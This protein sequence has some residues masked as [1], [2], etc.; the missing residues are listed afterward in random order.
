MTNSLRKYI[1]VVFLTLAGTLQGISQCVDDFPVATSLGDTVVNIC[2]GSADPIVRVAPGIRGFAIMYILTDANNTILD[3]TTNPVFNFR[4]APPGVCRI[5]AATFK[6]RILNTVGELLDD[7]E[8]TTLCWGLSANWVTIIRG[9]A[10]ESTVSITGGATD[11]TFC[12]QDGLDDILTFENTPTTQAYTYV[13]T[14]EN[15]MILDVTT[16]QVN[17]EGAPAGVCYVYGLSYDGALLAMPGMDVD[18]QLSEGCSRLSDNRVEVTRVTTDA[19]MILTT[20]SLTQLV[21]CIGDSMSDSIS[22]INPGA[23]PNANYTYIVTDD[24][25]TI[26]A[27]LPGNTVDFEG[28]GVGVCR[29][30]GVA[31]TGNLTATPGTLL[32]TITSDGACLGITSTFVRAVRTSPMEGRISTLGGDTLVFTCQGDSIDD[33][34][35]VN[36]LSGTSPFIFIITDENG[37]VLATSPNQ[38]INFEGAGPGTC[39]IWRAAYAGNLV[40]DAGDEL[41]VDPVSDGCFAISDNA[42]EVRRLN[43]DAGEIADMNGNT[44]SDI[45]VGDG[46]PDVYTFEGSFNPDAPARLVITDGDDNVL[47]IIPIDGEVDFDGAGSGACRVYG[48]SYAGDLLLEAG[49]NLLTDD[50]ATVCSDISDNFV[51]FNRSNVDPGIIFTQY[52]DIAFTC[53]GD[54]NPDLIFITRQSDA[55]SSIVIVTDNSGVVLALPQTDTVDFEGA[56]EGTCLI[57]NFAFD[58]NLLIAV[59]DTIMGQDLASGCFSLS[60]PVP[61]IRRV[62]ISDSL[63][64]MGGATELEFCTSDGIDDLVILNYGPTADFP[65]E[66]VITDTAGL[67]LGTSRNDTINFEGVPAGICYVYGVAYTG[68]FTGMVGQNIGSSD[69]SD[70]CYAI[71]DNFVQVTR[72]EPIGGQLALDNGEVIIY[73]CPSDGNPDVVRYER[74]NGAGDNFQYIITDEFDVALGFTT[75]DTF[76]FEGAGFGSCRIWG[77]AYAGNFMGEAGDT[78]T[79][80]DLADDCFALTDNFITVV[81]DTA[82]GGMVTTIQ[83]DTLVNVLKTDS[84]T[85]I[86]TATTVGASNANS[87]Y[88]VTGT[89]NQILVVL[90]GNVVDFELVPPG[91]YRIFHISY[92]GNLLAI[93]GFNVF[94]EQLSDDCFDLSDN[95]IRVLVADNIVDGGETNELNFESLDALAQR[96]QLTIAPNP[97]VD[98]IQL[99]NVGCA[100]QAIII[101]RIGTTVG[102]LDFDG[103]TNPSVSIGHLQA[104]LYFV[105]TFDENGVVVDRQRLLVN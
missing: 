44:S 30:Y 75:A 50:I 3:A 39:F 13:V 87:V 51:L 28:A 90:T 63:T 19:G 52:G 2:V 31:Y 22:F 34:V 105:V 61:V 56:G 7:A 88:V 97:A 83:G 71:S 42:V 68:F 60:D 78:I 85:F 55:D 79:T 84:T 74:L 24:S 96:P 102:V 69:L 45:C 40:I 82:E 5:Y 26:L 93:A 33:I 89:N 20:D 48:I 58:G 66:Y 76:D 32:N 92:T 70:D 104:G 73:T 91:E 17:F 8:L 57:W 53:P 65:V 43:A 18:G 72:T 1:I 41:F 11:T 9:S 37:R 25:D 64:A 94:L 15:G 38:E 86:V 10:D 47:N 99:G 6:G 101:D 29:V 21:I 27:V 62:P 12:S 14:D 36:I 16:G 49:D 81:R 4:N 23:D 100:N 77:V 59:G 35:T 80:Q 54:G 67:I 46:T 103:Q 98:Y 95:F